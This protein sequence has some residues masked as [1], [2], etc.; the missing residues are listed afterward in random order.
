MDRA[1]G[2]GWSRARDESTLRGSPPS[3]I[4]RPIP[5]RVCTRPACVRFGLLERAQGWVTRFALFVLL[6]LALPQLRAQTINDVTTVV[7]GNDTVVRVA[8]G[9]T[10]RFLQQSPTTPAGLYR[11]TFQLI[12]GDESVVKQTVEEVKQIPASG[13]LPEFTLSYVPAPNQQSKQ[14]TLQLRRAVVVQVRQGPSSRTID[15]VFRGLVATAPAPQKRFAVTLQ[16]LPLS[17]QD[18]LLPIPSQLQDL[19]VFNLNSV[20][21]GVATIDMNVGYF[22]TEEEASAI[23]KRVLQRFP[24]ARVIDVAKRSAEIAQLSAAA[25]P[26]SSEQRPTAAE[27]A[28]SKNAEAPTAAVSPPRVPS[29]DAAAP[30]GS[31]SAAVTNDEPMTELDRQAEVLMNAAKEDLATKNYAV[32]AAKFN[33]VLLLPPNRFSQDAQELIGVTWERAEAPAKARVEYTLYLKLYPEGEGAQRVAQ[34]LASLAGGTAGA[35]AALVEPGRTSAAAPTEP[36]KK[37]GGNIAQ[38]YYGGKAK[39]QSLVNLTSGIDQ[40][41][42]SK[43]TESAIVTSADFNGRFVSAES[44]TRIVVRGTNSLN[45]VSTSHSESLLSAAYIDYKRSDLTVRA[46][47]QSAVSGGLLGLFDGASLTYAL[48]DKVKFDL[49]GG[50]PANVLVSAPSQRLYAAV[51]EFDGIFDHWGG[52]VYV[53]DQTTESFT[54]R[55]AVGAEARYSDERLSLYSLLDYETTF[56]KINAVSL[57]GSFQAPAQTTITVLVDQRRAPSLALTNALISSGATSLSTLLQLQTLEQTRDAALATSATARQGLISVSRPLSEKWQA[58]FDVRFSEIGALPAVGNFEATPATGAQYGLSLQLTGSNLYS[59]RDI[60]S[61]N[62]TVL[63]TPFFKGTQVAYSNLTGLR[64]NT[65]T[66]EP[67]ISL[68]SQ[69]DTQDVK[70]FRV[71]P[72]LRATYR[73]S[74]RTS[75]LGEAIV[76]HST[77]DGPTNHGSTNSIFFYL[78]YRYELF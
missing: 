31:T 14:L 49:M 61:F 29:S 73:M 58:A 75:L 50:A 59:L 39:S 21:G 56:R 12:G 74:R 68:Y 54:N 52:N 60:N 63:S 33:Q 48:S 55:R 70:L 57:Q 5:R 18:K 46:G 32:A 62:I 6:A 43:T 47:R 30:A 25:T 51:V 66:I 13:Q 71:T 77:I 40:S 67:S 69:R 1:T 19:Y 65:V 15:L 53:V 37:F 28:A 72:G 27:P 20:V 22:E 26:P 41:T 7:Q 42:L 45:L 4:R 36:S 44:D 76:E 2:M 78:G 9:A 34:R 17:E 11:I 3:A 10:V 16:S 24:Q 23:A 38:Y 35:G 64:D 8:F